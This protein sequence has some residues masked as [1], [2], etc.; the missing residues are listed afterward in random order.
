MGIKVWPKNAQSKKALNL[1]KE[2]KE[3]IDFST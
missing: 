2:T 1:L 3:G